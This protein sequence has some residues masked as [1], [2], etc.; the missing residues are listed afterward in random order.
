LAAVRC[1]GQ[2]GEQEMIGASVTKLCLILLTSFF[3]V[4][5]SW[6]PGL[7]GRE[8]EGKKDGGPRKQVNQK[9]SK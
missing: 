4:A 3:F 9:D 6:I 2:F 5:S 1:C 7:F 8:R